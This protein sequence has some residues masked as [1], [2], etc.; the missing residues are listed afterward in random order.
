MIQL[1]TSPSNF[2]SSSPASSTRS[3]E[4][5]GL[6]EI[7]LPLVSPSSPSTDPDLDLDLEGDLETYLDP[8]EETEPERDRERGR[9]RRSGDD[10]LDEILYLRRF[11][12]LSPSESSLSIS[13]S[14]SCLLV[15]PYNNEKVRTSNDF[16][17][18]R[19]SVSSRTAL[20]VNR[21]RIISHTR[22]W[23]R[24][25]SMNSREYPPNYQV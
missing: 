19:P 24:S 23:V 11:V 6:L 22:S 21:G 17:G 20:W 18:A 3:G 7:Y 1:Y 14:S 12:F 9:P 10:S 25:S 16:L 8:T 2:P 15:L 5:L 4:I 13:A